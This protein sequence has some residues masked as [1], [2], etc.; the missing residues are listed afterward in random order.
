ME[1][2]PPRP[3]FTAPENQIK[4]W[5][6]F[7][8]HN[9]TKK[10]ITL[11]PMSYKEQSKNPEQELIAKLRII[12]LALVAKKFKK[13]IA[14]RF[15]MHRNSVLKII[16]EFQKKIS[17]EIQKKLLH[18]SLS[19]DEI[20]E[21]LNPIKN[22]SKAPKSNVRSATKEQEKIVLDIFH[23]HKV[24][25]G[26]KRFFQV[27]QR[28]FFGLE[29]TNKNTK[30]SFK[31][32][33]NFPDITPLKNLTFGQL[34]G[35]YKRNKLKAKKIKTTN[36][37]HRPLYDYE[38]LACF[39]CL[40]MDTK[41]IPDQKALPPEIYQKF[42]LNPELPVIEWNI[43]DAKSRI[44]FIA[45]SHNR[46][47]DFGLHFL[48]FV[49]QFL[50][51]YNLISWD[52][53][54][55]IGADNGTEFFSG[56]VRKQAEWNEYLAP[57]KASV[58]AYNPGHDVRKNLIE[59]SH[60][61][62]DEEFFIP[63]G[64]FINSKSDFFREAEHYAHY[65]NTARSHSGKGMNG[66]TPFEILQKSGITTPEKILEFPTLL[67]EDSIEDLKKANALFLA[68]PF[69]DQNIHRFHDPKF[70]PDLFAL[71]PSLQKNAQ[72]VLTY[73]RLF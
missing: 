53:N 2:P 71:F 39:E 45:Y 12:R 37:Q 6:Q 50:R 18:E 15:G 54:I 65:F 28:Q 52:L 4:W 7:F 23:K 44:R 32:S 62:D 1:A 46:T 49:I 8:T 72:N 69:L 60:K 27:L 64:F 22:H 73:Y 14:Q 48:L 19:K 47:S 16:R 68:R 70:F 51:A 67:L 20:L 24:K 10:M 43:I 5:D 29:Y 3:S 35:I 13:E 34:K 58:Y 42:C 63:R 21:F 25:V 33:E 30:L 56:S 40:H 17:P 26:Y 38:A 59:R 66:H 31:S 55:L 61:T 57:L 11:E 36:R 9:P 41:D